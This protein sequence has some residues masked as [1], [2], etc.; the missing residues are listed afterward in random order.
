MGETGKE[1]SKS[2]KPILNYF[3]NCPKDGKQQVPGTEVK[4]WG[5]EVT[6]LMGGKRLITANCPV[7]HSTLSVQNPKQK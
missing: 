3:V 6:E 2:S 7:C 4:D 5:D 1:E